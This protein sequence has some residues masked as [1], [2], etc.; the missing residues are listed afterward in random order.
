MG[1][2]RFGAPLQ[3]A[4]MNKTRTVRRFILL[5]LAASFGACHFHGGGCYHDW[6]RH[7]YVPARH[8]R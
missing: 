5:L 2:T 4:A 3:G 8:C 1:R 6:G 7:C